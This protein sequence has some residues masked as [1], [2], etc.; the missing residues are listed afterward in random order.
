MCKS[1]FLGISLEG[2]FSGQHAVLN[3]LIQSHDRFSLGEMIGQ[4]SGVGSSIV[5]VQLFQAFRDPR[6]QPHAPAG[7][8][9]LSQRLL[10][11]STTELVAVHMAGYIF[12]QMG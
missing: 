8:Y 5:A 6:V 10:N 9:L 12:D 3:Q 1:L 4:L 7:S 2:L 11:Q